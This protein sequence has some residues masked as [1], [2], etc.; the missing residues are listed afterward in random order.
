MKRCS[1]LVKNVSHI[2][3]AMVTYFLPLAILSD[4]V[5]FLPVTLAAIL[6]LISV[7]VFATVPRP[8]RERADSSCCKR[9]MGKHLTKSSSTTAIVGSRE[10]GTQRLV[11]PPEPPSPKPYQSVALLVLCFIF[12]DATKPMLMTW[13]HDQ[14]EPDEQFNHSEFVL[15]QTFLSLMVGLAIAVRPQMYILHHMCPG[16]WLI[17]HPEWRVRLASCLDMRA[18]IKQM[19]VSMCLC[20]SKILLVTA[21]SRLDAGTVRVFGQSSLPLVGVSAALFFSKRYTLQQWF[22]LT[23]VSVALVTFYYVKAQVQLSEKGLAIPAGRRINM[24]GVL[25]TIASIGFNCLGAVLVEKFLKE[26]RGKLHEQK[27]QL[28]FGEVLVN[29]VFVFVFPLF[30]MDEAHSPYHRGFFAGWD[31][32]VLICT[33]VWIPAG[34]TATMLVKRCSNV[35][36]TM[37]Q[38]TSGVL[39]YVFSVLPVSCGPRW[40]PNVVGFF[41]PPLTPEP[42]S[43]PVVLLAVTVMLSALTFGMGNHA[44]KKHRRTPIAADQKPLT[45]TMREMHRLGEPRVSRW[46]VDPSYRHLQKTQTANSAGPF[47]KDMQDDKGSQMA[48]R[49]WVAG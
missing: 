29:A 33:L 18:V 31:I 37:A 17:V 2:L 23:A 15:V 4:S 30:I 9:R 27:S 8:P 10:L 34:W 28:L 36:K 46:V 42:F 35:V 20:L 12:L 5:H 39:T 45:D 38:S 24:A 49:P 48:R 25:I 16:D 7:L 32:R 26:K 13:A 1:A 14:K 19:P 11:A 43:S 6:V 40:W 3:S 21:L 22:S 44:E 41:G 47:V